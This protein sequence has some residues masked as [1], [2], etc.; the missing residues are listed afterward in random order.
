MTATEF[1]EVNLRI[2]EHQEEYETLPVFVDEKD[3]TIPVTMCFELSSEERKQVWETGEIWVT[4]LTFGK[5]F[6]PIGMS[7]LKPE[8]FK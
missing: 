8:G 2:A 3:P 4:M 6:Q 5:S 7:L 1:K